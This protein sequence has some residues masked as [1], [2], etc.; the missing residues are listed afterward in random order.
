[1]FLTQRNQCKIWGFHSDDWKNAV[2]W[3]IKSQFVP[4]KKHITYPLQ[5]PAGSC[6][7]RFED[8]TE[9]TTKN[10]VFWDVTPCDSC[11]N[12]HFGWTYRL[13]HQG[14]KTVVICSGCSCQLLLTLFLALWFFLL[15][16][17]RGVTSQKTAFFNAVNIWTACLRYVAE[18][19]DRC[20]AHGPTDIGLICNVRVQLAIAVT[21]SSQLKFLRR[22][23]YFVISI[24]FLSP[25]HQ[26]SEIICEWFELSC[27]HIVLA[28]VCLLFYGLFNCS[29]NSSVNILSNDGT[30]N[31]LLIWKNLEYNRF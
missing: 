3:N 8:L 25:F 14:G 21:G 4:H 28:F 11:K 31:C 7:V 17:P 15:Q 12:R 6:Y 10:A 1:V 27:S 29:L 20:S 9:V 26:N 13:H 2:F 5:R 16:E 19:R 30:I 24:Q 18:N 22:C 23:R